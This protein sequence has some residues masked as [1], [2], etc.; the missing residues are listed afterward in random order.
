MWH[1]E[2]NLKVDFFFDSKFEE[3]TDITNL[4]QKMKTGQISKPSK[5]KDPWGMHILNLYCGS[6]NDF[7][8]NKC[9]FPRSE[10]WANTMAH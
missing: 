3:K 5:G 6:L 8:L 4:Q 1:F 7:Y 2:K 9:Y 10:E